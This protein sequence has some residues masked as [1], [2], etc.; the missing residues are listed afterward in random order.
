MNWDTLLAMLGTGGLT[1]LVN[2]LINFKATR[3]KS[4][5]DKDDLSRIMANRDNETILRLYD[6]NRNILEKLASLESILFK[7]ETCRYYSACPVRNRLREYQTG[8][9]Y[10]RHPQP[11]VERKGIRYPRD[12]P[13]VD[14]P[15]IDSDR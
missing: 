7:L 1:A 9:N 3:R 11:V 4:Q 14:S 8:R 13:D 6:E 2:W 10:R 15:G 12:H 5:L